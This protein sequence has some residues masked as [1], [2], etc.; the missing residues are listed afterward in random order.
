MTFQKT[1]TFLGGISKNSEIYKNYIFQDHIFICL[2]LI[3]N[4]HQAVYFNLEKYKNYK[5]DKNIHF[6]ILSFK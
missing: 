6:R 5:N 3:K 1:V 2:S 4:Y